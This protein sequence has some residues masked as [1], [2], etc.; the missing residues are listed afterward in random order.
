MLFC[1]IRRL[2]TEKRS[3]TFLL[4]MFAFIVAANYFSKDTTR[5]S[6]VLT[7]GWAAWQWLLYA[8]FAAACLLIAGGC[9]KK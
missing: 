1:K 5:F 8:I 2:F 4:C 7:Y 6:V 3:A 9:L